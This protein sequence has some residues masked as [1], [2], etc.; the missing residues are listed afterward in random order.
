[1]SV[2]VFKT[3]VFTH[4]SFGPALSK[5]PLFSA[6]FLAENAR[7]GAL[8]NQGAPG[9]ARE[10]ADGGVNEGKK[11]GKTFASTLQRTP[12]LES[13]PASILG[14]YFGVSPFFTSLPGQEVPYTSVDGFQD[15]N[16]GLLACCGGWSLDQELSSKLCA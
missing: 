4:L 3:R 16:L 7:G 15:R 10:G 12:I 14:S 1:M 2:S 6:R 8:Q 13:T 11:K 9:R 5:A